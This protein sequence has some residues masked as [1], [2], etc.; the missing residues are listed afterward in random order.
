MTESPL[1]HIIRPTPPWAS[2]R[3]THCGREITDVAKVGVLDHYMALRRRDGAQRAAYTFCV[4]CTQRATDGVWTATGNRLATWTTTPA[5]IVREWLTRPDHVEERTLYA[6][7]TLVEN[8]RNEFDALV[9]Q[10]GVSNLADR[11]RTRKGS[12]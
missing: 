3:W 4:T 7:A 9:T 2:P 5:Q 11:R 6:L 1:T 10:A 12:R 8:H